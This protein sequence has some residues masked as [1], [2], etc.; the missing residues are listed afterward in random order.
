MQLFAPLN[1]R[2]DGTV[3]FALPLGDGLIPMIALK[4]LGW[5]SRHIFD[6]PSTTA[7]KHLEI[8]SQM[9]GLDDIIET[10]KRVTGRPAVAV[11]QTIDEHFDLYQ[12]VDTPV[13]YVPG[14]L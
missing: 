5:W 1:I 10:F 9:V 4:D 13:K 11:R 6:S 3:V 2:P 8:A 12:G 14:W 7:G